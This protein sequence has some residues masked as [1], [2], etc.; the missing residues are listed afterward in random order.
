MLTHKIGAIHRKTYIYIC[1]YIFSLILNLSTSNETGLF[2]KKKY[3]KEKHE[4]P[5][6]INPEYLPLITTQQFHLH[7]LRHVRYPVAT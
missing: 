5:P 7:F 2:T 1:V 4:Y 6:L 3:K